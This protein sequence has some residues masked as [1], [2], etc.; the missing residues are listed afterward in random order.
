MQTVLRQ[1]IW[2]RNGLD[3]DF[4]AWEA[5]SGGEP[6]IT[7]LLKIANNNKLAVAA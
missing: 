1:K 7:P 5:G 4:E 6:L 2:G 3:G